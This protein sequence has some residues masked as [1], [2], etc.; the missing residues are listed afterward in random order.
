M[1]RLALTLLAFTAALQAPRPMAALPAAGQAAAAEAADAIVDIHRVAL[2]HDDLWALSEG[3]A[4]SRIDLAGRTR[5]VVI[6]A[7]VTDLRKVGGRVT[8]LYGAGKARRLAAW[9]GQ[10]FVDGP[11]PGNWGDD[12]PWMIVSGGPTPVLL[13]A[14]RAWKQR[15]DGRW[16]SVRLQLPQSTGGMWTSSLVSTDG[17]LAYIGVD[18]G[19]WG[20]GLL[21]ISLATGKGE[22]AGRSCLTGNL[23]ADNCKPA[24]GALFEGV[25]GIIADPDHPGC[26]LAAM[27]LSHM[28]SSGAL[29]RLCGDRPVIALRHKVELP[30]PPPGYQNVGGDGDEAFFGLAAS[31]H[32]GWWAVTQM[33]AYHEPGGARVLMPTPFDNIG[34]VRLGRLGPGAVFVVTMS[35]AHK[36]LAGATPLLA[37]D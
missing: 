10:R 5:T 31:S 1:I 6:S 12:A 35:R 22:W 26:L 25:H 36:S 11:P 34:G 24:Q 15:P 30:P 14:T 13:S 28:M 4:L 3:G 29:V 7:D 19:E 21:R 32:G 37:V 9:D 27:G 8:I 33:A 16:L 23:D 17:R 2:D 18:R 20:G